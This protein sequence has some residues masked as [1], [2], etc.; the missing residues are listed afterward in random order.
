MQQSVYR[1]ALE[2]VVEGN[3]S[4]K[5]AGGPTKKMQQRLVSAARCAIKMRSKE[6]NRHEAIKALARDLLNGPFHCFG[7][8][9]KCSPDFCSTVRESIDRHLCNLQQSLHLTHQ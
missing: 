1:G 6:S 7:Q 8:H 4:Y 2:R 9:D 3:P 5:G